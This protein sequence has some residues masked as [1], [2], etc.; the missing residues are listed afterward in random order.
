MNSKMTTA[1]RLVLLNTQGSQTEAVA[2]LGEVCN[3]QKVYDK[4]PMWGDDLQRILVVAACRLQMA[5]LGGSDITGV[6]VPN[7]VL[8]DR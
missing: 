1:Q 2:L 5:V 4:D 7:V 3:M 8:Q 6:A